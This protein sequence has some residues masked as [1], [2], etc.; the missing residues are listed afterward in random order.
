VRSYTWEPRSTL[1]D[2]AKDILTRY[3]KLFGIE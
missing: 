2:N 1:E 3:N